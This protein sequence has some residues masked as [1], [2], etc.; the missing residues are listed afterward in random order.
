MAVCNICNQR[1]PVRGLKRLMAIPE[2]RS[3]IGFWPWTAVQVCDGCAAGH[4]RDFRERLGLLAPDVLENDEPVVGE[5]C[6]ACGAT[7]S[8]DPWRE[9]AKWV[10]AA[11]RPTR[12]ARF[13]LCSRHADETYV[14]GLIVSSN[15]TDAA[16]MAEVFEELPIAG[17]DLLARVEGW[18]PGTPRNS[19]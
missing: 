10:D 6:L 4:D 9:A 14:D 15:L 19:S 18:R 2:Y 8:D 7:E 16:R 11:G 5:V 1:F 13:R 3:L 12:R 17:G